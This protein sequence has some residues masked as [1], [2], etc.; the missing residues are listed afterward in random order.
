LAISRTSLIQQTKAELQRR[1]FTKFK[2]ALYKNYDHAPHLEALDRA[3]ERVS[4]YAETGGE[5]G[6]Y[7]LLVEMPPRHGK[8]LSV[9][10]LYPAWHL[11][12]NPNHRIMLVSYGAELAVKHSRFARAVLS[13]KPY[14]FQSVLDAGSHAANAWDI[15]GHE[16][17]VDAIGV[18]GGATGKGANI[19]ICDDLIKNRSEAESKIIRDRTWDALN[20]DL[21]TR[22]EPGGAVIMFATRWHLDDPQGR[23]LK[24]LPSISEPIEHLCFPAIAHERDPLGRAPGDALWPARWPRE[25][26]EAIRDRMTDYSWGALYDQAPIAASGGLFKAINLPIIRYV[27]DCS[28]IVRFWDLAMSERTGADYTVGVKMGVQHNGRLVVLDVQRKRLEWDE[29]APWIAQVALEDGPSVVIGFEQKGYMTR[30]GK[31]LATDTRLHNHSVFGYPKDTDKLTNALPF[32][33]RVGQQTVDVI[34]AWW[35]NDFLDELMSFPQG[36]H[37]DQVDAAAGAYE[38]LGHRP[39]TVETQRYA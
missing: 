7:L 2:R 19:L 35:N 10:R 22:L 18:L 4:L 8:S 33:A 39:V 38:M 12:R 23:M 5:R 24:L 34:E 20:D 31:K 32:A 11:G 14:P 13:S 16:G 21:L 26:L 29:V 27:P 25:R 28:R 6:T 1:D 36:A 15:A 17:G 37:D 9:S 30:A 3:L